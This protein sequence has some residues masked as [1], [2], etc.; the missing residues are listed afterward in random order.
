MKKTI[1]LLFLLLTD[2]LFSNEY[3]CKEHNQ[4]LK[5]IEQGLEHVNH[6]VYYNNI[7]IKELQQ[8]MWFIEKIQ[9]TKNGFKLIA[10][11]IQYNDPT[12]KIF[13]LEIDK[14]K[15]FKLY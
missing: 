4:K 9:C 7:L 3:L 8:G 2:S 13:F 6:N 5:I 10:S 1:L 15:H 14:N 12:T 11:H